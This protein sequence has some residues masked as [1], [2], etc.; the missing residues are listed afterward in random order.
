MEI[1]AEGK[2]LEH[3]NVNSF[4][5]ANESI[6]LFTVSIVTKIKKKKVLLFFL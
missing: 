4:L 5:G 6:R 2:E 3:L 1:A